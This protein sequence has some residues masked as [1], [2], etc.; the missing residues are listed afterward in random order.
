VKEETARILMVVQ[1]Y[2][3]HYPEVGFVFKRIE[4]GKSILNSEHVRD[5]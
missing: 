1:A 3:L 4:D 2:C 5:K